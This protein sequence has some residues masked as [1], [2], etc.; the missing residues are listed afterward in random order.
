M[1]VSL[2]PRKRPWYGGS[3][4]AEHRL[5]KLMFGDSDEDVQEVPRM[6][7]VCRSSSIPSTT[8]SRYN[9]RMKL[10]DT[11]LLATPACVDPD[12]L[13]SIRCEIDNCDASIRKSISFC[14]QE[15]IGDAVEEVKKF[16]MHE[17][18]QYFYVGISENPLWRMHRKGT[19][20]ST[21]CSVKEHFPVW[22]AMHVVFM[23]ST[24]VC[25]QLEK[26][27]IRAFKEDA[28]IPLKHLANISRGGEGS[29]RHYIPSMF[30][31]VLSD[32]IRA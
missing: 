29:A 19:R 5:S 30:V 22:K 3:P 7:Q 26:R 13:E 6:I 2:H 23:A 14:L 10:R 28:P 31:Y 15:T 11:A 21:Q 32:R 1:P 27:L 16:A 9:A 8:L 4:E 24:V 12:L 20:T 17:T 18:N 25:G